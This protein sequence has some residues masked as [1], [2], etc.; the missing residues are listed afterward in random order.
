M[1]E[2]NDLHQLLR[3]IKQLEGEISLKDQENKDQKDQFAIFKEV[4]NKK[5][6]N[7]KS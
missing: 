6:A 7:L 3:K 2:N 4:N 5:Q 1:A